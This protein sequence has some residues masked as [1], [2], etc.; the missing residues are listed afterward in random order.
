MKFRRAKQ[1]EYSKPG[2]SQS[3]KPPK[4]F[5][6]S[7]VR[8]NRICSSRHRVPRFASSQVTTH[9]FHAKEIAAAMA[10]DVDAIVALSGDGLPHEI[11]NGLA[12]R[13][14]AV[15]ALRV[16][17]VPVPTGSANGF[18][19]SI[20]GPKASCSCTHYST[21]RSKL[22]HYRTRRASTLALLC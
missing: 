10:L 8:L 16:P 13:T 4:A 14:D 7:N 15:A 18:N 19:I 22:H 1:R 20:H 2:S 9:R 21:D 5:S 11:I 6:T 12:S 3:S 17:I